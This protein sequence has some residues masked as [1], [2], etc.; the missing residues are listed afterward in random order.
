MQATPR[1]LSVV[2]SKSNPRRRLIRDVAKSSKPLPNPRNMKLKK[3][4]FAI[5]LIVIA[6]YFATWSVHRPKKIT[7]QFASH[8]SQER[9]QQCADML[10]AP[11]SMDVSPTGD[12]V[13]VDH[14]GNSIKV[15]KDKLP[16]KVGGGRSDD[17]SDFSM[18]ALGESSNGILQTPAVILYLSVEGG[19]VRIDRVDS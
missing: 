7:Q 4:A 11:S 19:K 5:T 12:L 17:P 14:A 15:L 8:F 10:Q 6:V 18:T 3:L 1:R 13:L 2:C 9:Y 16:F